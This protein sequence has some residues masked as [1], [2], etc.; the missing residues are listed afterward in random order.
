MQKYFS[1]E[2]PA[3]KRSIGCGVK[4]MSL[5]FVL[6][7]ALLDF[8]NLN[9][10][11]VLQNSFSLQTIATSR[12]HSTSCAIKIYFIFDPLMLDITRILFY[13]FFG[14]NYVKLYE[15]T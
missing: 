7:W 10:M 3:F 13:F 15:K 9:R 8:N 4:S 5:N 2:I 12:S 6:A 11:L 1:L 14:K